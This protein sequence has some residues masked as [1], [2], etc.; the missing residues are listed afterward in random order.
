M[1]LSEHVRSVIECYISVFI[2]D[3][4]IVLLPLTFFVAWEMF[5]P[6]YMEKKKRNSCFIIVDILH[7]CTL[8]KIIQTHLPKASKNDQ[9]CVFKKRSHIQDIGCMFSFTTGSFGN[10]VMLLITGS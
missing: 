4:Y 3:I 8:L 9:Q 10:F 2:L 1:N 5:S 6:S 7:C